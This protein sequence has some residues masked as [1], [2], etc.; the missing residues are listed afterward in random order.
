MSAPFWQLAEPLDAFVFDCDG[1]LSTIEG[2]D[3]LA[4]LNNTA[5]AVKELTAQAMNTTG[6]NIGLYAQRLSLTRPTAEQLDAVGDLYF[7][8]KTKD[9]L[10]V[11]QILR[12]LGKQ[13]F[14]L[15]AGIQRS[16]SAFAKRLDIEDQHVFAVDVFLDEQGYYKGFDENCPLVYPD[17]KSRV[18]EKL[19]NY[20][21]RICHVGDGMNDF[22]AQEF[23]TRFVGYGGAYYRPQ[24][25]ENCECYIKTASLLPLLPLTLTA[26]EVNSLDGLALDFYEQGCAMLQDHWVKFP[27]RAH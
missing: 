2:I 7:K 14:I 23:S 21:P 22:T 26:S 20:Y 17:G 6:I 10:A 4:M 25:E 15:S 8:N 3:E 11:L 12:F 19:K 18:V 1:T 24:L 13:V 9:I 16:V 27:Q 5:S